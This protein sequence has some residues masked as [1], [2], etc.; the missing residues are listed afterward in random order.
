MKKE[1]LLVKKFSQEHGPVLMP[2]YNSDSELLKKLRYDT[3]YRFTGSDERN[4]KH[5]RKLFA[6]LRCVIANDPRSQ[7]ADEE[8]LLSAVKV[9]M[10]LTHSYIDFKGIT[11]VETDSISFSS[12]GQSRF[13]KF[14][15]KAVDICAEYIGISSLELEQ[16]LHDYL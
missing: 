8:A 1:L 14:Y 4:V 10:G 16:N 6:I 2:A 15:Q 12:M 11:R 9:E 5:H 7:F 13:E 3:A